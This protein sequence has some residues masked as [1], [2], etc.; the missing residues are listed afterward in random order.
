MALLF[1]T[2]QKLF[3][4]IIPAIH[5]VNP[6]SALFA[7]K[8]NGHYLTISKKLMV[9]ESKLLTLIVSKTNSYTHNQ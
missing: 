3:V 7:G 6:I 4:I 1:Q 2:R 5:S 8:A 9:K